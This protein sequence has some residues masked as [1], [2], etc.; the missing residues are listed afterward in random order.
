MLL[1]AFLSM[2]K[3]FEI[4]IQLSCT[5]LY[6]F[7]MP[8]KLLNSASPRFDRFNS[9]NEQIRP[10]VKSH[11]SLASGHEKFPGPTL[12]QIISDQHSSSPSPVG[13]TPT[14]LQRKYVKESSKVDSPRMLD[15]DLSS[16]RSEPMPNDDFSSRHQNNPAP[17]PIVSSDFSPARHRNSEDLP[18]VESPRLI[19]FRPNCYSWFLNKYV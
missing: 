1:V 15:I 13:Y 7:Q 19:F 6:C 17:R 4:L 5:F 2:L 18:E 9:S 10:L 12:D 8:L 14:T 3:F 11:M 16:V